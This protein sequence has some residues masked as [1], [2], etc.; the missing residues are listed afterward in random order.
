M[1]GSA[2]ARAAVLPSSVSPSGKVRKGFGA[3]S[4]DSGHRRVPAPPERMIGTNAMGCL[5]RFSDRG[6]VPDRQIAPDRRK[7][8]S[9]LFQRRHDN[10]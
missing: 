1:S 5:E 7:W 3:V 9:R 8:R 2:T 10:A 6:I 4:R